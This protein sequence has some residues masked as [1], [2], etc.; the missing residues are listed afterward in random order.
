VFE[1]KPAAQV[2]LD[3]RTHEARTLDQVATR[4]D[5]RLVSVTRRS[6]LK[7]IVFD[8]DG[9]DRIRRSGRDCAPVQA[10]RRGA[11]KAY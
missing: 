8:F 1:L 3:K 2:G 7:L 10:G 5:A 4:G 6:T 9:P 11:A